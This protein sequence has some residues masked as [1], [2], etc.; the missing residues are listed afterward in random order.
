MPTRELNSEKNAAIL[1]EELLIV[2]E[3]GVGLSDFSQRVRSPISVKIPK[4]E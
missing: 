4:G 3:V 1:K 2:R